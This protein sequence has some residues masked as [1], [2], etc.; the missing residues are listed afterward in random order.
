MEKVKFIPEDFGFEDFYETGVECPMWIFSE[1]DE[2]YKWNYILKQP[3]NAF[4]AG[5]NQPDIWTVD[6]IAEED[7]GGASRGK[8]YEGL[9]PTRNFAEELFVNLKLYYLQHVRRELN[10]D[11]LLNK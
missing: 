10:L 11:S 4:G 5:D 2:I 1:T 3:Y 9:I 6:V 7:E 8:I